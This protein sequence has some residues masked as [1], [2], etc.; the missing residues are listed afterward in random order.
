MSTRQMS[1]LD[2]ETKRG[3]IRFLVREPMGVLLVVVTLVVVTDLPVARCL[4]DAGVQSRHQ[5]RNHQ[6]EG[7]RNPRD[8]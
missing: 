1:E 3:V 5:F 8:R 4:A 2:Q 6:L 7:C